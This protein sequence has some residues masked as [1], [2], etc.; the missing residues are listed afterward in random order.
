MILD[1]L[2]AS[3]NY[4][5]TENNVGNQP[6][7]FFHDVNNSFYPVKS[8]QMTPSHNISYNPNEYIHVKV[9]DMIKNQSQTV[10]FD[11]YLPKKGQCSPSSR[12]QQNILAFTPLVSIQSWHESCVTTNNMS[13]ST[14]LVPVSNRSFM[15][16]S[17][18]AVPNRSSVQTTV[19]KAIYLT[20]DYTATLAKRGPT[21]PNECH[22]KNG[23]QHH[24]DR[25]NSSR[26]N[27]RIR[28]HINH[29]HKH[30]NSTDSFSSNINIITSNKSFNSLSVKSFVSQHTIPKSITTN[31]TNYRQQSLVKNHIKQPKSRENYQRHVLPLPNGLSLSIESSIQQIDNKHSSFQNNHRHQT[32]SIIIP[33]IT[34]TADASRVQV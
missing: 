25:S 6:W 14:K 23:E 7:Q 4:S 13:V 18:I 34:T 1:P 22:R 33:A 28:S 24:S 30:Q 2:D 21:V 26:N 19:Q 10:M 9:P 11:E 15:S 3:N 29:Q 31:K 32:K 8:H 17:L 27:H 16:R 5:I 12:Q 20:I